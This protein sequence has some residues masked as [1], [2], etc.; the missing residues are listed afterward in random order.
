MP[1]KSNADLPESVQGLPAEAKSVFRKVANEQLAKGASDA[2]AMKIGWTAVKAGWKKEGDEWVRKA[3]DAYDPDEKEDDE[4]QDCFES[5]VVDGLRKTSDGYLVGVA[6]VGRVGIQTYSGRELG[7]PD[8]SQVRVYRPE[9]EVFARDALHSL[10]HRPVT[11]EHPDTT[12]TADNWRQHA[13]GQ[14]GDEIAR[15]GDF[16][17]VPLVLMDAKAIKQVEDGKRELSLGYSTKLRWES[18]VSPKGEAY[19]AVQTAI[20]GNHLAIVSVARGGSELRLGDE[21][22]KRPMAERTITV[23]GLSVVLED[24]DAQIVERTI[25]KLVDENKRL[26]TDAAQIAVLQKQVEAK[27]GEIV[28]LKKQVEDAALTPAKLDSAVQARAKVVTDARKI[29]GDTLAV[30][31]KTDAEIKR[32]A[33]VVKLGDAA[34]TMK[35]GEIDGAFMALV[36][37]PVDALRDG[38]NQAVPVNLGDAR[39]KTQDAYTKHVQ[40]QRDAWKGPAAA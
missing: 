5:V 36:G 32:A 33:V 25:Q 2:T 13:V 40:D 21:E 14:T 18:G 19:D 16:V 3:K 1:W 37:Q 28:V 12:V 27:D 22:R 23:D 20:R 29:A 31:G 30:D 38:L 8:L 10:A 39:K 4:V 26:T 6:R 17:R 34:K 7:R 35:D 11:I 9:A 15:D 24:R